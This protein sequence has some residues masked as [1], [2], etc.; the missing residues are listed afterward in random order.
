VDSDA[1]SFFVVPDIRIYIASQSHENPAHLAFESSLN[2]LNVFGNKSARAS[3]VANHGIA[4][5]DIDPQRGRINV[6]S[7]G[8]ELRDAPG[9]AP[10]HHCEEENHETPPNQFAPGYTSALDVHDGSSEVTTATS[11][12]FH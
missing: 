12:L 2:L 8:L 6:G 1:V 4:F 11:T 10:N 9:R 5:R 3:H 7:G